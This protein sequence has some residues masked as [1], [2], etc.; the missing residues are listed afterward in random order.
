[1]IWQLILHYLHLWHCEVGKMCDISNR[2][3]IPTCSCSEGIW[4]FVESSGKD[5]VQ[6]EWSAGLI[7]TCFGGGEGGTVAPKNIL[8]AREGWDHIHCDV[9]QV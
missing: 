4:S 3:P 9:F 1:M 7:A 6:I 5:T 2:A 8:K